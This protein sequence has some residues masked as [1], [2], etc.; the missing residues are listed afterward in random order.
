MMI[1]LKW[2]FPAFTLLLF[3]VCPAFSA[4]AIQNAADSTLSEEQVTRG[5]NLFTGKSAF[6]NGGP[7]CLSCHTIDDS[8]LPLSGG[9]YSINVTAFA[10]LPEDALKER[11]I[12]IPFPHMAV[13]K[14]AFENRPVT[15]EESEQLIAYLKH[16]TQLDTPADAASTAPLAGINLLWRGV[17][18]L[19]VIYGFIFFYWRSRK[20]HSV[21]RTIYQRQVQSV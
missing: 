15:E 10:G 14:A 4:A 7:S 16:V 19:I 5:Q 21:N 2:F 8:E 9:T 3:N 13:M 18:G 12:D 1:T 11:I 17:V 20:K 6:S